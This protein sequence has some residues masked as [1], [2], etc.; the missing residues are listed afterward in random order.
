MSPCIFLINTQNL[1]KLTTDIDK[2]DHTKF[3]QQTYKTK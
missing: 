1:I 2:R 3:K